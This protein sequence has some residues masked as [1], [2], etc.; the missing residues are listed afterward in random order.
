MTDELLRREYE[1][2]ERVFKYSVDIFEFTAKPLKKIEES[3]FQ[4]CL[5]LYFDLKK[6]SVKE[7]RLPLREMTA[8]CA[9]TSRS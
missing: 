9:A 6:E 5:E 1:Q 8:A 3:S 2:Q 4:L 7:E